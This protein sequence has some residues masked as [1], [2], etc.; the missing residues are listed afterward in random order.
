L[1]EFI[2]WPLSQLLRF[3]L[4]DK[5]LASGKYGFNANC[6]YLI[7]QQINERLPHLPIKYVNIAYQAITFLKFVI[8]SQSILRYAGYESFKRKF[9][10]QI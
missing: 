9:I 1:N 4:F 2:R 10:Y 3:K 6:F 5:N 8:D 7:K